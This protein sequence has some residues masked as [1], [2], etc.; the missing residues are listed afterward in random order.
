M[1]TFVAVVPPQELR[2]RI[3]EV[4]QDAG[5]RVRTRWTAPANLHLTMAFL[6]EIDAADLGA[7][8]AA[9]TA[10]AACPPFSLSLRKLGAFDSLR[11]ARVLFLPAQEG[12]DELAALARSLVQALPDHLRPQDR[13]PFT[14][15]LTLARPRTFPSADELAPLIAALDTD[16]FRFTVDALVVMESRL[17]SRGA[18]Y[19]ERSRAALRG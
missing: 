18:T 14:A 1:R 9:A 8:G 19:V 7:V 12:F 11:R 5:R 2:E 16:R 15:H 4:V 6:G 17:S 13:R 10:A 3:H